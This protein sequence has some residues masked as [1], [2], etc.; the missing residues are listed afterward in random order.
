MKDVF[1]GYHPIVNVIYFFGIII[2]SMVIMHPIFLIISLVTSIC[3]YVILNYVSLENSN[4]KTYKHKLYILWKSIKNIFCFIPLIL[5]MGLINPIF[6]RTGETVLFYFN[7]VFY[8][9][10]EATLYGICAGLMILSVIVWF[11][12]YNIIVSSDKF[13]YIFSGIIPSLAL[14]ISMIFRFIPKYR[15]QLKNIKE[16]QICFTDN[17]ENQSVINKIKSLSNI[18]FML[19]VW[20]LENSIDTAVSMKSRGYGLKKRTSFN[21]YKVKSKD[22]IFVFIYLL[23]FGF[24]IFGAV[25]GEMAINFFPVIY[26]NNVTVFSICLYLIYTLF[27]SLPIIL[28]VLGELKWKYLKSKI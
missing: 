14:V 27:C 4:S 1:S 23:M 25:N 13:I 24:I 9:T 2:L 11:M 8:I 12:C 7:S 21:I 17:I 10:L 22:I 26:L 3:Y 18:Y 6:N 5:L 20:A 15:L 19:I 16:A 28:E